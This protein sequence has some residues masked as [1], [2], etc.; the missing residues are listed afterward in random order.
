MA[1]TLLPGIGGTVGS[2][3]GVASAVFGSVMT[4]FG[5]PRSRPLR[6]RFLRDP[7]APA[8]LARGLRS[9]DLFRV[10]NQRR[11]GRRLPCLVDGD[12][13]EA[14]VDAGPPPARRG[15]LALHD[16]LDFHR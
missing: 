6:R 15:V 4:G 13:G 12:E 1:T 16:D 14:R 11:D 3:A 8:R 2:F 9:T 5:L 7:V 10:E